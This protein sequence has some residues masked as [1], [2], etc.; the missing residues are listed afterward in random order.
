M[1][2]L[3]ALIIALSPSEK[4]HF[5]KKHNQKAD[6]VLLFDYINKKKSCVSSEVLS[7]L[8]KQKSG[9]KTYSSSYLSVI[10]T[11][12]INKILESLRIQFIHKKKNYELLSR[13]MNTDILLEK[14]LY[15]LAKKEIDYSNDENLESSFP[16]ERLLLLRR[17]SILD[18]FENY[19]NTN[20]EGINTLFRLRLEAAEQVTI[21]I[22][23]ARILSIL[24]FQYFNGQNDPELLKSFMAEPYLQDESL[25]TDFSTRY[26]FH[27]VHA[28]FQ[29]FQNNNEQAL[30]HFNKSIEIWIKKPQYIDAHPRM[31]LGACFTY[32]K[33]MIHQKEP[34][35]NIL[36]DIN[37]SVLMSKVKAEHL[38]EEEAIKYKLI[39]NLFQILSLREQGNS[40]EI[41]KLVTPLIEDQ[42]YLNEMPDFERVIFCY[43]SAQAFFVEKDYKM[44]GNILFNL[45]NPLDKRLASNPVYI[46]VFILLY[47]IILV[48]RNNEKLLRNLLPKFKTYLKQEGRLTIFESQYMNMVS[49]LISPRF[50][51]SQELVYE[52]FYE[53]LSQTLKNDDLGI[54]LEYNLLLSWIK[55]KKMELS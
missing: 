4:Q 25:S 34:L 44:A 23:L 47:T 27:W 41:I 26:L 31:F 2:D 10:K 30:I 1:D 5:K 14:G 8:S 22:K 45:L 6:F 36:S 16:I 28:Q 15:S 51:L 50:K 21:E 7:Y 52:R 48:E 17:K 18:Y 37:F 19:S 32:F 35:S 11:Y 33:Y 49:Q 53:R 9:K 13:S 54:K 43:Y 20:L 39:F 12:L 24:S 3:T 55:K 40:I 29:E 46:T 38:S 42:D